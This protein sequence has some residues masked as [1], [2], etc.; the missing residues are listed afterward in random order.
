MKNIKFK[1][2]KTN[3]K[4]QT[5]NNRLTLRKVKLIMIGTFIILTGITSCGKNNDT[6]P[7]NTKCNSNNWVT[8][9]EKELNSFSNALIAYSADP[10]KANCDK[11]KNAATS[12]L[13]SLNN[14]KECVPSLNLTDYNNALDGAKKSINEIDCQ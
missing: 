2:T 7:T 4:R 9:V 13:E 6:S 5:G 11:Y 3:E 10:T 8:L 1:K 14:I 12:Y